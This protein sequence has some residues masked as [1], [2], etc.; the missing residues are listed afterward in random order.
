MMRKAALFY[1]PSSGRRRGRRRADV[2]AVKKVF[3]DAGILI[4]AA[5]TAGPEKAAEQVRQA[6]EEGCDTVIACGGDGTIHDLAQ[7]LVGSSVGL[8]IIPLGTANTLAH[9]LSIPRHPIRAAQAALQARPRRFAV[10]Q[11][12]YQNFAGQRGHRYFNSVLGVGVDAHLFY[13]LDAELK[14]RM[15]M[16]A[17]YAK[18][19]RLLLTHRWSSFPVD[20]MAVGAP[21]ARKENV[22]QLLAVR[23]T[24][25]GGILRR[26]APGAALTR[27]DLR[28]VLFKTHSRLRFL[29]YILRGLAGLAW[30]VAG[31]ELEDASWIRC[32]DR[33][34][35]G[36]PE[37]ILVEADGELVGTLPAEISI[38]PDALTLLVPG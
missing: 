15:G 2:Q 4:T 20:Y 34:H 3:E 11:V 28:L 22:S 24:Q 17:Y 31:I 32:G 35:L 9:D 30:N 16:I 1:N 37:R 25:F 12:E 7:G 6:I 8:A 27:N 38:V 29:L 5:E 23:I 36:P 14:Q 21:S 10:G 13:K 33:A 18:A 19:V 26:L